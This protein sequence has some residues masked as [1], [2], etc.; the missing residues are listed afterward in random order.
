MRNQTWQFKRT[1]SA[2]EYVAAL[3]KLDLTMAA[4]ARYLDISARHSRRYA[5]GEIEI[6]VPTALL[7]RALMVHNERPIVPAWTASWEAR[8]T[9]LTKARRRSRAVQE[10]IAL[11]RRP[12]HD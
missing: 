6:P 4:A 5:H 10:V 1:M 11:S 12:S 8:Q 9:G 2:D 7:L 3:M